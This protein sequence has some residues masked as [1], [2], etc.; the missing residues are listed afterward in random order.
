[1][2]RFFM[3]PVLLVLL[4][5]SAV[6]VFAAPAPNNDVYFPV[7]VRP[8][9]EVHITTR[10]YQAQP[11]PEFIQSV[12]NHEAG[13]VTGVYVPDLLALPVLQQPTGQ[14]GYVAVQD[15]IVTQFSLANQYHNVG[16]L[17]HN[18]LAGR[19]FS[20][21]YTDED[22]VLVYGDGT[23]E[24]Y[25]I[26]DIQRY[27]ALEPQSINSEFVD[28][29]NGQ[30]TRLSANDLFN[31]VYTTPDVVVFQTCIANNGDASWGR[32]FITAERVY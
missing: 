29:N 3:L 30:N 27:Q 5:I 28:L 31:R 2:K 23:L 25:R 13:V 12:T 32:L 22:V 21:L 4:L 14:I 16:L 7:I 6:P 17:A 8:G 10:A 18:H 19:M 24:H 11:S 15:N 26:K 1:M 20:Q 9:H